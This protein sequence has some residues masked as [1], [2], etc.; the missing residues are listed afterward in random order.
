MISHVVSRIISTHIPILHTEIRTYLRL[1]AIITSS[2]SQQLHTYI[3][4]NSAHPIMHRI[5]QRS[6][7]NMPTRQQVFYSTTPTLTA[8]PANIPIPGLENIYPPSKDPSQ[9]KT[10]MSKPREEYPAWVN[11]L[12]TPLPTL[13]KL[14][15]MNLET[16]SD[17][18][19]KRYLKLTRRA[20]I[21]Q[22]NMERAKR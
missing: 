15:N 13:A 16:A 17:K 18:D 3:I 7:H 6:L 4:M 19:M 9:S 2:K 21:K 14:R 11:N 8:M 5:L 1:R 10:P 12:T 22:Q 20:K